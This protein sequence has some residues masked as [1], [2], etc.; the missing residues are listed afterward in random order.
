MLGWDPGTA[1]GVVAVDP[2]TSWNGPFGVS[3]LVFCFSG[4]V[5]MGED[6]FCWDRVQTAFCWPVCF[7]FK[8]GATPG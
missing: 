8:G 5:E 4:V 1:V 2:V 6:V 3:L 7:R